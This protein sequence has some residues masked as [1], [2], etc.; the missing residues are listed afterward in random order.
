MSTEVAIFMYNI[1]ALRWFMSSSIINSIVLLKA[2]LLSFQLLKIMDDWTTLL[3]SGDRSMLY[4]LI[5]LKHLI[6]SLTMNYYLNK[7]HTI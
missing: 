4:T 1:S 2:D 6:Q 7:N 3:D 5:L